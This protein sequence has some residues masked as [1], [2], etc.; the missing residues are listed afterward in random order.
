MSPSLLAPISDPA[1]EG[2]FHRA[3]RHARRELRLTRAECARFLAWFEAERPT[4]DDLTEAF[5]AHRTDQQEDW[6]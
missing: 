4:T 1:F 3:R 5:E 6:L 2:R